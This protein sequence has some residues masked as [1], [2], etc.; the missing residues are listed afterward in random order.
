MCLAS[1]AE[2]YAKKN[3]ERDLVNHLSLEYKQALVLFGHKLQKSNRDVREDVLEH[4]YRETLFWLGDIRYILT[5]TVIDTHQHHVVQCQ[6]L[7]TLPG[8]QARLYCVCLDD[9]GPIV[10]ERGNHLPNELDPAGGS[11]R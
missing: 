10:E 1:G 4:L 3:R 2:L 11:Y 6:I 8:N 7:G 5:R 9:V